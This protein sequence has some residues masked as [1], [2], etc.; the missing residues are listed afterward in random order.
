MKV[1]LSYATQDRSVAERISLALRAGGHAVFFDRSDLL[2]GEEYDARI[3]KAIEGSDLFVFL[4]SPDALDAG[5][6]TLTELQIAQKTWSHPGGRV[7]PVLLR[8][9]E[10]A[11]L[12]PYLR[13]VTVLQPAGSVPADVADAVHRIAK[14]RRRWLRP[15]LAIGLGAL[16]AVLAGLRFLA[17]VSPG[18]PAGEITGKDG[19]SALLV[20]QGPFIM[21]DDEWSPKREVHL[22]GFYMDKYEVSAARY[23]KFLRAG[24]SVRKPEYWDDANATA[25]GDRPVVGVRWREAD[26]YCRWAGKRLPTEAEWEKA[27]RGTDGRTFPWGEIEPTRDLANFGA[28]ADTPFTAVLDPVTSHGSGQSPY[29]VQNLAGNVAEWVTD[30]F[31]DAFPIDDRWNPK[32]PDH[33]KGRVVRGGGWADASEALRTARRY[34]ADPQDASNDRGF[35]CAQDLPGR[36]Q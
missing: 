20:P 34:Y 9:T 1:F 3:R 21:G 13:A 31:G 5:S 30:W 11:T 23:D 2:P 36:V 18:E 26:A 28:P 27:A 17:S 35:R 10:L 4:V 14:T 15:A 29:G 16:V 24:G 7:L 8:P 12:S 32:G 22:D 25:F 19:A 33:G 6:Y